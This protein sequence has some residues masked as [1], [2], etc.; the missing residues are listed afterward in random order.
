LQ[1]QNQRLARKL[2]TVAWQDWIA[3]AA[4]LSAACYLAYRG[5]LAMTR[6]RSAGC[7][8]CAG[9]QTG[10]GEGE[11]VGVEQLAESARRAAAAPSFR[12]APRHETVPTAAANHENQVLRQRLEQKSGWDQAAA[13]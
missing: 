1:R 2:M 6:R 12:A 5:W 11:L 10:K 9:C 13:I 4:A 8:A 3:L 7:G